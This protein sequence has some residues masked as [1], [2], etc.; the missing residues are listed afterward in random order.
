MLPQVI[1]HNDS[2][3]DE[4][5][6]IKNLISKEIRGLRREIRTLRNDVC[7]RGVGSYTSDRQLLQ[8][9]IKSV[10][11]RGVKVQRRSGRQTRVTKLGGTRKAFMPLKP[12][13]RRVRETYSPIRNEDTLLNKDDVG[14]QNVASQRCNVKDSVVEQ[15]RGKGGAATLTDEDLEQ[16]PNSMHIISGTMVL[17][18]SEKLVNSNKAVG[19]ESNAQGTV[20]TEK[21]ESTDES[22]ADGNVGTPEGRSVYN[23]HTAP[24]SIC[25]ALK[26]SLSLSETAERFR[27]EPFLDGLHLINNTVSGI[28]AA[29]EE[30]H[31][32]LDSKL[33]NPDKAVNNTA[34]PSTALMSDTSSTIPNQN[35]GDSDEQCRDGGGKQM[36]EVCSL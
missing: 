17:D 14:F 10:R 13:Q 30:Q 19:K 31:V 35:T 26:E 25:S 15:L 29:P 4:I 34:F 27:E 24:Q 16:A 3:L 2:I 22:E 7:S 12:R 18:V 33:H 11:G 28:G 8:E 36:D 23:V 5:A 20:T 32:I 1:S 21:D 6:G 9:L